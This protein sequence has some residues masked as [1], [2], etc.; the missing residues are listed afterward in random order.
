MT[1][2]VLG[3]TGTRTTPTTR[4]LQFL[5]LNMCTLHDQGCRTLHHGSCTGWDEAAHYL[6]LSL[7]WHVVIHP[8]TN[9]TYE[10]G[11]LLDSPGS[12]EVRFSKPYRERDQDIV[13]ESTVLIGGPLY[14]KADERS[15]RSGTWM[16]LRMAYDARKPWSA[17]FPDGSTSYG[18]W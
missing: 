7:G 2:I 6:A 17:V 14:P 10:A 18:E 5:Y 1:E 13:N 16:T 3:V 8:P 12:V 9:S 11:D 4:Q 15:K